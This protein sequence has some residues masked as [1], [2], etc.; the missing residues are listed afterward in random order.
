MPAD[1]GR[2]GS[3]LTAEEYA[4]ALDIAAQIDTSFPG[5][6]HLL[7]RALL[8]AHN[9]RSEWESR[10]GMVTVYDV[11]GHYKGCMGIERW[12][13]LLR[14]DALGE[15]SLTDGGEARELVETIDDVLAQS[16]HHYGLEAQRNDFYALDVDDVRKARQ[17][18]SALAERA[19][20]AERLRG[21]LRDGAQLGETLELR[22][23]CRLALGKLAATPE[24]RRDADARAGEEAR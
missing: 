12:A 23:W 6:T 4:E 3:G 17:A 10:E 9:A 15:R 21:W 22:A 20:E 24:P 18:L 19:E 1:P 14:D 16:E 2:A 5:D 8:H 13:T 7:A 11:D